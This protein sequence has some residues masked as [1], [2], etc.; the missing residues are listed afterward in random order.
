MVVGGK[1]GTAQNSHGEDHAWFTAIAPMENPEIVVAVV[2][3]NAGQ[4]GEIAA[5]MVRRVLEAY[6]DNAASEEITVASTK[7]ATSQPEN[8][9]GNAP[10][11]SA[12]QR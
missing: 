5:P 1:T 3:E 11:A 4:G 7:P 9:I 10:V 12:H 8:V 2:V 6:F